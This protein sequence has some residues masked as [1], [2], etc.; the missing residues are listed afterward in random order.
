MTLVELILILVVAAAIGLIAQY[1]GGGY[2][3]GGLLLAIVLG[4]V[5]ALVGAWLARRLG[6]PELLTVTIG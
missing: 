4:F 3:R 5:G 2:W 6:L 1:L